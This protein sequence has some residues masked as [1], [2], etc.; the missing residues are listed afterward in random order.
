MKEPIMIGKLSNGRRHRVVA[1]ACASLFLL[2]ACATHPDHIR[3]GMS[4]DEVLR[5]FGP[6]AGQRQLPDGEQLVY[7][8]GPMG[9]YAYAAR[10][11]RDGRVASVAQALTFENFGR[12]KV[13]EWTMSMVQGEY[14]RPAEIRD[15]R[16][17]EV[18]WSYRYKQ[19]D[20]WHMMM[21]FYFDVQGTL[22]KVQNTID[23]MYDPGESRISRWR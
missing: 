14:G 23:P 7:S 22:R 3:A 5:T 11:G 6:P 13:G 2:G 8:T 21:T 17:G 4:R 10:L 15:L 18:W 12:A 19:N 9:F 16:N 1:L 20:M